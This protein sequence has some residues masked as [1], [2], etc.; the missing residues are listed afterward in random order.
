MLKIRRTVTVDD[1][2]EILK[3]PRDIELAASDRERFPEE[4]EKR[5]IIRGGAL[6]ENGAPIVAGGLTPFRGDYVVAW[7]VACRPLK[8]YIKLVLPEV[9]RALEETRGVVILAN[10]SERGGAAERFI[11][12]L[13]FVPGKKQGNFFQDR[14]H[15]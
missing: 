3:R 7:L 13:G 15:L 14:R 6:Y 10:V 5:G 4:I 1:V 8:P 2:R 9:Q 12:R 11:R